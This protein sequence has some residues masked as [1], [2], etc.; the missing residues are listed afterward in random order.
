MSRSFVHL[1]ARTTHSVGEGAIRVGELAAAAA[2]M[3]MA[4]VG[5]T[6]TL[7][8]AAL[9][10]L[11]RS[12]ARHGVGAV[13]GMTVGLEHDGVRGEAALLAMGDAGV[14]DLVAVHNAVHGAGPLHLSR[15]APLARSGRLVLL[16]GGRDGLVSR[17]LLS[18][19]DAAARGAL[20]ALR[21]A[22][23]DRLYVEVQRHGLDEEAAVEGRLLALARDLGLPPVASNEPFFLTPDMREARDVLECVASGTRMDD[24]GRR[25]VSGEHWLKGQEAMLDLFADLPDA[26]AATTEI[27]D[28]CRLGADALAALRPAPPSA[29]GIA[30]RAR[31]GLEERLAGMDADRAAPYRLRLEEELEEIAAV[32]AG[33]RYAAAADLVALARS[34]GALVGTGY[35]SSA[36]STVCWALGVTGIDPLRHGLTGWRQIHAKGGGWLGVEVDGGHRDAVLEGLPEAFGAGRTAGVMRYETPTGLALVERVARCLGFTDRALADMVSRLKTRGLYKALRGA[37]LREFDV[38][39]NVATIHWDISDA[40]LRAFRLAALIEGM[41]VAARPD[42]RNVCV[43]GGDPLRDTLPVADDPE[44]G[45]HVRL[46]ASDL[47]AMGVAVLAVQENPHLTIAAEHCGQAEYDAIP[48]DDPAVWEAFCRGDVGDLPGFPAPMFGEFGLKAIQPHRIADLAV[49][50]AMW[51]PGAVA[52]IRVLAER[53]RAGDPGKGPHPLLPFAETNGFL[54]FHDQVEA[55]FRDIAGYGPRAAVEARRTLGGS[56]DDRK[57]A[58]RDSFVAAAVANGHTERDA[59]SVHGALERH[60]ARVFNRPHAVSFAVAAYRSLWLRIH[61]RPAVARARL[62]EHLSDLENVRALLGHRDAGRLLEACGI[63]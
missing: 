15:L 55:A 29:A 3:G 38:A 41:P 56:D 53:R 61:R 4:A 23:P 35:G 44:R 22:F 40:A 9:P 58:G 14:A 54:V 39:S 59:L 10:S 47:E 36:G 50:Y 21:S 48:D 13:L 60:E 1:R 18:G 49:A 63:R 46:V 31:L 34:K 16:T 20:D 8:I 45:L 42:G 27:A 33:H 51:R 43:A 2:R 57:L 7:S 30:G 19:A 5:V 32:G 26:C 37:T 12:A 28:R 24:G 25:S 52:S 62:L 17:A 11:L 6:D